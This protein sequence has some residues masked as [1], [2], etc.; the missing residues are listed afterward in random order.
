MNAMLTHM[1]HDKPIHGYYI[2]YSA[3][4]SIHIYRVYRIIDRNKRYNNIQPDRY[5]DSK[6]DK[7]AK[8]GNMN[9]H[10][11]SKQPAKKNAA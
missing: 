2:A 8:L 3:F 9:E 7:C 5:I 6:Y 11:A 10:I 4:Y 1:K